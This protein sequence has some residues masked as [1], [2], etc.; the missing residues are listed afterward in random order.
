M[1]ANSAYTRASTANRRDTAINNSYKAE[2]PTTT[3]RAMV[4]AIYA[5]TAIMVFFAS[6]RAPNAENMALSYS[7]PAYVRILQNFSLP[8]VAFCAVAALYIHFV[9]RQPTNV[10]RSKFLVFYYVF[11][12]IVLGSD[13]ANSGT[14]NDFVARIIFTTLIFLFFYYVISSLPFYDSSR[15]NVLNAFFLGSFLFLGLNIL[16]HQTGLGSVSWKGRLLGLT[17]H[18]N[19]IGMC[20]SVTA[21]ISFGLF[22][23]EKERIPKAIYLSG[24]V[25]GLWVCI[26][27]VSRTS[28]LGAAA[29][30][31]IILLFSLKNNY[32]KPLIVLLI[33]LGAVLAISYID[34]QALDYANR[35]NTRAETWASMYEEAS[36]LPFF[37]KGRSGATT[38]AYLFAIVAGGLLGAFFF[39]RTVFASIAVF[40]TKNIARYYEKIILCAL[41]GLILVTSMLE[42]YLLDAA[43]IPVFTYWMILCYLK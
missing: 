43:G 22:Y 13:F 41:I 26:L 33:I 20:G 15:Y 9:H 12:L 18:P 36:T 37:G 24:V 34:L 30:I 42:G 1:A 7:V 17:T 8:I 28:M 27:S 31:V 32:L 6:F 2:M 40:F 29:A 38:N 10:H 4:I 3:N 11:H 23:R 25:L 39:F 35:G 16:L 14:L 19:F 5:L 21:A